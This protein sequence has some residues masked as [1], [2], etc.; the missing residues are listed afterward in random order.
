MKSTSATGVLEDILQPLCAVII[1]RFAFV[2]V[3][4]FTRNYN[5]H[6]MNFWC[7]CIVFLF[8]VHE[9]IHESEKHA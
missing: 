1:Y 4:N 2:I 5:L 9:K 8:I 7:E 6:L 3:T